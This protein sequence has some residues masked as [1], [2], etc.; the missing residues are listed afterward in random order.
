[1]KNAVGVPFEDLLNAEVRWNYF[2]GENILT[3]A[4]N[5]FIEWDKVYTVDWI[6]GGERVM[7]LPPDT[8]HKIAMLNGPHWYTILRAYQA[9]QSEQVK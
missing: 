7:M 5:Q 8:A 9:I 1:M 6:E 4:F 2:W 3:E